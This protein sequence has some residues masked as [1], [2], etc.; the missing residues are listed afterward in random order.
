MVKPENGEL[1]NLAFSGIHI[2]NSNIFNMIKEEGSFSIIDV[3]LYLA[4]NNKIMSFEHNSGYW[5]DLGKPQNLK[6]A[7]KAFD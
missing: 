2:I 3:Y 5:F 6:D 7:E 4:R 1:R